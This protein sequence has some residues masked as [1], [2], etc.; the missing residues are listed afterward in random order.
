M[1]DSPDISI[2]ITIVSGARHL[3]ACLQGLVVQK[4]CDL[5]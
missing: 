2:V 1:P 4:D 3:E 5:E